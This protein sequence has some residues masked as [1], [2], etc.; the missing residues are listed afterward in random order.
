M[1]HTPPLARVAAATARAS[2]VISIEQ[3]PRYTSSMA[4]RPTSR[5]SPLR[6][7]RL[8]AMAKLLKAVSFSESNVSLEKPTSRSFPDRS[9]HVART[10]ST[11]SFQV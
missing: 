9:Y 1:G 2:V 10:L 8:Y 7:L 6:P 3:H 4:C 11:I 5:G